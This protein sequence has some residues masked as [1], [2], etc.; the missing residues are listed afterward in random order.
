M[1]SSLQNTAIDDKQF[2]DLLKSKYNLK[3]AEVR[4]QKLDL[5]Q[6][7]STSKKTKAVTS[8][9]SKQK[10]ST[11][12]EKK[13]KVIKARKSSQSRSKSRSSSRQRTVPNSKSNTLGAK[14]YTKVC[15]AF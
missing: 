6:M 12:T 4:L 7:Q 1:F 2:S 14:V 10:R 5:E 13:V 11:S 9:K 15:R 8:S 3:M